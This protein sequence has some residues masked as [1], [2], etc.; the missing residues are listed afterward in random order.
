MSKPD[1][2]MVRKWTRM[3]QAGSEGETTTTVEVDPSQTNW[4][5]NLTE[6]RNWET[7]DRLFG[8]LLS[9]SCLKAGL[10]LS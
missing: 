5:Y 9:C 7:K 10:L 1:V 8:M 6:E 4:T 2:T 3:D